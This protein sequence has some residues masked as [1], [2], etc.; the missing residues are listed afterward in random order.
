ML[1]SLKGYKPALQAVKR[2][3]KATGMKE[4]LS[5]REGLAM[6]KYRS[7]TLPG[8]TKWIGE[9]NW[10]KCLGNPVGND[11]D[12]KKFY[13]KKIQAVRDKAQNWVNLYKA[14]YA[15]RN[16]IVQAMYFG[17]LRYWLYT[18]KMDKAL[19][20]KSRQM[21]TCCGGNQTQT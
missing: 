11:L 15:G 6:G 16:L 13:T 18:L 4:N 3:G 21:P 20:K 2:W 1:A 19:K 5:K 10:A 12:H 9:G 8:D 17:S 7:K 14:S